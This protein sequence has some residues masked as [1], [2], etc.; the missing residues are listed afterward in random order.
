MRVEQLRA[1]HIFGAIDLQRACFPP[2]FDAALLWRRE[3]LERHLEVFP[4]GQFV[5]LEGERVI[6][7]ASALIISE[8]NWQRHS[9][10]ETTVGGHFMNAHESAGTTLYGVD[11]SVHPEFRG[12]G[13]GRALYCA[14]FSLVGQL[15]L[16]RFGSA[17]R[18]PDYS[19]ARESEPGLAVE[20]FCSQV[21]AGDRIDRTMTPL[22]RYGLRF[23]DV[24]HG[25]M[26]DEESADAAALLEGAP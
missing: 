20:Q 26:G 23:V 12:K 4:Q 15:G 22:L 1:E 13:V 10:W 14:R 7:S 8:T 21:A 9:D 16:A 25:Y 24:I 6:G 11:I 18:I 19:A 5:A 3:H 17:C 2:P